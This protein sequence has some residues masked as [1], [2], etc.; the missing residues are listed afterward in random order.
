MA[1]MVL[2]GGCSESE[3]TAPFSGTVTYKGQPLEFGSVTFQPKAGGSLAR[4][5]IQPD[6]TFELMTD[7]R[8]GA[9]IGENSVR[10]TCFA[11]QKP[12]ATA[13][14]AGEGSLGKSLIPERYSRFTTSGLT[15]E[16]KSGE[17]PPY[18]IQ[19]TD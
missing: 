11:N 13:D 10:V 9:P 7:G 3:P 15:V 14:T 4:A 5:Q 8:R 1:A 16:V 6:G 12:G 18:E 2:S 19:L 17:N